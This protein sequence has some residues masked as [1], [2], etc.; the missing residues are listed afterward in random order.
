MKKNIIKKSFFYLGLLAA[1]SLFIS[2][3]LVRAQS[4]QPQ[5]KYTARDLRDP[6]L[7]IFEMQKLS[8][9]PAVGEAIS[10]LKVQGMIWGAKM[11]QAIINDTVVRV[12]EIV[13]GAEILEIRKE[14]IYV[15]YQGK[16]YILRPTIEGGGR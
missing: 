4:A 9:Q 3:S 16:Q 8:D 15:L 2:S 5:V 7:S 10:H 11:P 6:F 12:G 1:L 14:G 13:G